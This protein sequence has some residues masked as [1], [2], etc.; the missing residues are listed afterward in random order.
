MFPGKEV[1]QPTVVD[2]ESFQVWKDE[3]FGLWK[4]WAEVYEDGSEAANVLSQV[5]DTYYL[6]SIVEN[7]YVGGDLFSVFDAVSWDGLIP[8]SA[9]EGDAPAYA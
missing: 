9:A 5:H 4:T 3:A 2:S 8:P 6:M 7:D 1:V